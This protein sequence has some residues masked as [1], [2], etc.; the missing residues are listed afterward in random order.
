MK[1]TAS[2]VKDTWTVIVTLLAAAGLVFAAYDWFVGQNK[3]KEKLETEVAPAVKALE[4]STK[5]V[6]RA[7]ELLA[8]DKLATQVAMEQKCE[9]PNN[10]MPHA[11]C[12]DVLLKKRLREAK[13]KEELLP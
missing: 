7:V 8:E 2:H 1:V 12:E 3:D 11:Y 10:D 9:E 5:K 4:R 6:A 13:E